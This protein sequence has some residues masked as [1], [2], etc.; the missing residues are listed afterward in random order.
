[1][2]H[3]LYLLVMYCNLNFLFFYFL[4]QLKALRLKEI[5]DD[6]KNQRTKQN[7][8]KGQKKSNQK[9]FVGSNLGGSHEKELDEM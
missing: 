1:M 6:S 2:V 8:D 7:S 5:A 3:S 4:L 9:D